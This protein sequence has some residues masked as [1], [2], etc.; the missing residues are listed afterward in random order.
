VVL[1]LKAAKILRLF[2]NQKEK[3]VESSRLTILVQALMG[4]ILILGVLL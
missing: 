2:Y 3:L 4:I 1:N